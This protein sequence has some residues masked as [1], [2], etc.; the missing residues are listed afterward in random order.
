MSVVVSLILAVVVLHYMI[1]LMV[2]LGLTINIYEDRT[3]LSQPRVSVLLAA[4]NEEEHIT[5]CLQHLCELNYPVDKIEI[6]IGDDASEDGTV[7]HIKPFLEK[8]PH[9]KLFHISEN[10]GKARGKANVL[11]Q[12]AKQATGDYFFITDADIHVNPEWINSMLP[13]VDEQTAIV[14]G[15]TIG[16][17][18]NVFEHLQAIDWTYFNA[19]LTGTSNLGIPCTAVGNNMLITREAYLKTGGY[20][21]LEF[22]VTEDYALYRAVRNL[23]L[24]TKNI[25]TTGSFH[26]TRTLPTF[27][28][29]LHQR[30]RWLTGGRQLP[31]YWWLMLFI[32]GLFWPCIVAI[33]CINPMLALKCWLL[34]F[35]LETAIINRQLLRLQQPTVFLFLLLHQVYSFISSMAVAI[36]YVLPFKFAWK[37][38]TY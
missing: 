32:F 3:L 26:F 9:L 16:K 22:S 31:F 28:A 6:L 5:A 23:S 34:K 36:F 8:Y 33:A 37:N 4:R 21:H 18:E 11:A 14:S 19:V 20:E 15:I 29:V 13:H 27:K 30:K 1:Q 38:R 12:L 17:G 2:W 35:I 24:K 7:Q 10:L 25:C